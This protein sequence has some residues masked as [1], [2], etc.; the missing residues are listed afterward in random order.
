MLARFAERKL[1]NAKGRQRTDSTHVLAAVQILNRIEVAGEALRHAL[2]RLAVEVPAWLKTW[3]PPDWFDRY[4]TRLD[5]YRLPKG[6]TE[7]RLFVE[8]IGRDG[9]Q[10]LEAAYA[11]DAPTGVRALV[12]IEILRQVWVQSFYLLILA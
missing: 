3:V 9:Y 4:G 12:E 6:E 10:V 8:T 1:L 2:N 5:D 7:R 11:P